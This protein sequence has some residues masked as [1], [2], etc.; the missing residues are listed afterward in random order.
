MKLE[1]W[2][3]YLSPL[4]YQQHQS[5]ELLF[6]KYQFNDLELLY[7]SYEMIPQ[8]EPDEG[9][10]FYD[11]L[12][13]HHVISVEEAKDICP[14][15][16]ESLKPVKVTDVHRL[17]HLAKKSD[18]AFEFNQKVFKSY[19]EHK[20]DIS[21]Q[22][23]LMDIALSIGLDQSQVEEVLASNMF[24][25]T[26]N[27]NRENAILKGIFELPHIRID[28]KIRLSGYHDDLQILEALMKSSAQFNKTDYCEGEN[29]D[30]KKT[31]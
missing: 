21:N 30:R 18:K 16:G 7:R 9:C 1:F 3:D 24:L 15:I 31:R 10:T 12:A 23:V 26:V 8:F 2:L 19:Y 4:C 13:K 25:E 22:D 14:H 29:C 17:S 5:I 28:G 20:L 6:K 27:L 11:V